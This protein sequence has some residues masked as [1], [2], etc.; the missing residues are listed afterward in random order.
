M[1][2]NISTESM[3]LRCSLRFRGRKG[4]PVV[5]GYPF[6]RMEIDGNTLTFTT[7][8]MAIFDRASWSVKRNQ[9]KKIQQTQRG[10]RFFAEGFDDPWVVASLFTATFLSKLREQKIEP[11]GIIVPSTWDTI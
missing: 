4:R 8:R 3:R 9:I 1:V 11:R 5:V 6:A 7:G 10:V 2:G